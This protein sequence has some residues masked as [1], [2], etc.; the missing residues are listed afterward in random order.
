D[1]PRRPR[2]RLHGPGRSPGRT[3]LRL[4]CRPPA[5]PRLRRGSRSHVVRHQN[6]PL[7]GSCAGRSRQV[8]RPRVRL[9]PRYQGRRPGRLR[10][11][12]CVRRTGREG[13]RSSV[14]SRLRPRL[15]LRTWTRLRR[16]PRIGVRTRTGLRGSR[17]QAGRTSLRCTSLRCLQALLN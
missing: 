17:C 6:G 10:R 5:R 9:R 16:R 15:R 13:R 11:S 12:G 14:W 2:P 7:R 3:G 1:R 4:C 8:G